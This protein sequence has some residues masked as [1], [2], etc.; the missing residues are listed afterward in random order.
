[1]VTSVDSGILEFC[2]ETMSIDALKKRMIHLKSLNQIYREI[3]SDSF[4]EAQ[5]CF[6][7]SLAAYSVVQYLFQIKDRHNGIKLSV[8]GRK[9]SRRQARASC[10]Y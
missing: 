4:E 2:V 7:D 10:S 3:F 8:H 9:Y 6:I 5:K 1:M